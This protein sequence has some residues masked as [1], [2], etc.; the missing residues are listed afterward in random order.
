MLSLA[1]S[2]ISIN[3]SLKLQTYNVA[4]ILHYSKLF[5]ILKT[6]TCYSYWSSVIIYDNANEYYLICFSIKSMFLLNYN[7]YK[8]YIKYYDSE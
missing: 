5:F 2:I 7:T 8:K 4:L 1:L 6:F 3:S